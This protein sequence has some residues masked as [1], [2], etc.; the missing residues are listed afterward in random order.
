MGEGVG[1]DGGTW[2]EVTSKV[3]S[4]FG[5]STCK[6]GVTIKWNA[7]ACKGNGLEKTRSLVLTE[8]SLRCLVHLGEVEQV[9]SQGLREVWAGDKIW[10]SS[11]THAVEMYW[12]RGQL[13][14]QCIPIQTS[15]FSGF[16]I[17]YFV[18]IRVQRLIVACRKCFENFCCLYLRKDGSWDC[19]PGY[20]QSAN[21]HRGQW[22]NLTQVSGEVGGSEVSYL[23]GSCSETLQREDLR[24]VWHD[25]LLMI[26]GWLLVLPFLNIL[27]NY[28]LQTIVG[29]YYLLNLPA[30][31][32]ILSSCCWVY[33][34]FSALSMIESPGQP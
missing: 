10:A 3:I 27:G 32:F 19:P 33:S 20:G 16:K 18:D 21:E 23:L 30:L 11:A 25:F 1:F 29:V 6:D 4:G 7:E 5:L 15:I 12:T 2:E 22:V 34:G 17:I 14:S 28:L 9:M 26:A 13:T 8:L 24:L 31:N